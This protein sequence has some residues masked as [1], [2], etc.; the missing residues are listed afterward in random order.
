LSY[1]VYIR[2]HADTDHLGITRFELSNPVDEN[3]NDNSKKQQPQ[4]Q[5]QLEIVMDETYIIEQNV[6]ADAEND[7]ETNY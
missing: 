1:V 3:E 4:Q 6:P 2:R 5:Q 7:L